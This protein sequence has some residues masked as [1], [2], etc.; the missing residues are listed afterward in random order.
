MSNQDQ[1]PQPPLS[2]DYLQ[3]GQVEQ[4]EYYHD[5]FLEDQEEEE[6][7]ALSDEDYYNQ[8]LQIEQ[9]WLEWEQQSSVNNRQN[10]VFHNIYDL[11]Q[12]ATPAKRRGRRQVTAAVNRSTL[13]RSA[14][15]GSGPSD[16][17]A[18]NASAIEKLRRLG[19]YR[20]ALAS[21]IVHSYSNLTWEAAKAAREER[22]AAK[23]GV[24]GG[25]ENIICTLPIE[26][27]SHIVSHLEPSQ[28]LKVSLV[29]QLFYHVVNSDSCWRGAFMKFFGETIPFKRLDP[30][31]WRGEYIKRTRLL[32]RWEKGRGSN[33]L[34]DPKIGNISTI[35]ADDD[36]RSF[37]V[38]SIDE[39]VVARCSPSSD[40]GQKDA[41]SRMA[42]LIDSRASAMA[43]DRYRVVWGLTT[44]QVSLTTLAYATAGQTFQTFNGFHE[45]AVTCVKLVPNCLEFVLTGGIDG[46]VRLWDVSK[47]RT[48]CIFKTGSN[49]VGAIRSRIEYIC[50]E[51]DSR[52]VAGTSHGEIYIWDVD[53]NA[54]TAPVAMSSSA[55]SSPARSNSSEN[56]SATLPTTPAAE[57]ADHEQS[58]TPNP[59]SVPVPRVIKLPEDFRGVAYLEASFWG[60]RSGLIMVHAVGS[61]VMHLYSLETLHHIATLESPAHT[62]PISA[63]HWDIPKYKKPM[64]SI[65]KST[66][67]DGSG[68]NPYSRQ[69]V[70]SLLATGDQ[71][72]NICLWYLRDSVLE[73]T[74][75]ARKQ[76]GSRQDM[77]RPLILEPMCVIRAHHS[78]VVSL[79]MDELIIV[80]GCS[81]GWVKTWNPVNGKQ[82]SLLSTGTDVR[83]H[84]NNL[85]WDSR[86]NNI[87]VRGQ[88]CR[89][90]MSYGIFVR[91]WD[92]SPE[93][94]LGKARN[95]KHMTKRPV[96]YSAGS[97]NRIQND[98]RNSLQETVSIRRLEE[99][100]KM[101]QEQLHRR[102]HKP[103]SLNMAD[104]TDEEVV[105][106]V[107]M[108][109][110]DQDDQDSLREASEMERIHEL[111]QQLALEH[112][113]RL[114]QSH[115][116]EGPSASASVLIAPGTSALLPTSTPST[117][118]G[119]M[120]D[121]YVDEHEREE[122]EAL[123]RKAIAMSLLDMESNG[124]DHG[125]HDVYSK[126]NDIHCIHNHVHQPMDWNSSHIMDVD[127]N[128]VDDFESH[129]D[130]QI[131]QSILQ[132]LENDD[133]KAEASRA[134]KGKD[135]QRESWPNVTDVTPK[136]IGPPLPVSTDESLTAALTSPIAPSN[137]SIERC[138]VDQL[139]QEE[140]P[141]K[142]L[143]WSMVARTG[144][145]AD[146]TVL[147]NTGAGRQP[148]VIKQYA[149][150]AS[151]EEIEDEDTQ[152]A[153]ILSLSL[154]EK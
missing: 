25:G 137:V 48:V 30:K 64:V 144:T 38:G 15:S 147:S 100:V 20:P 89:G 12:K 99:Q 102:Y 35:S 84:W 26:I 132:E 143:T 29:C 80:S 108:L 117:V 107:M 58:N 129:E 54:I 122:E 39:G 112:Q 62:T 119:R 139:K 106:Y 75:V 67:A 130:Q 101:R 68:S 16:W 133:D 81:E 9:S 51:P 60:N 142:K 28:L 131:V 92:F 27:L 14:T 93:A 78:R 24:G 145:E 59:M 34:M 79:F 21:S 110:K 128:A 86:F 109:S 96:H 82:V 11:L 40:R 74:Q 154:I 91:S 114:E 3:D 23:A 152:L 37:L 61:N 148:V 134:D 111:E 56:I 105:E 63:I 115:S 149:A 4:E 42:R 71:S 104:M 150:E 5:Q 85:M 19:S 53:I 90:V 45:G 126:D 103:E 1:Y 57:A 47:A 127:T 98:I 41:V 136:S 55:I 88:Q 49:L 135:V 140:A 94:N 116:G 69:G 43:M 120:E 77:H 7:Q 151:R 73:A 33:I 121:D 17:D 124:S 52:I 6:D 118:T 31:T 138:G 153:R 83:R 95:K 36:K 123:V 22:L 72:G 113:I 125:H 87:A 65:T 46:D 76:K 70:S 18:A 13:T 8:K 44:G 50:C 66:S 2:Q 146:A 97:K 10:P 141:A 32:R